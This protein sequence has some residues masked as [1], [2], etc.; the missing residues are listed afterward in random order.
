VAALHNGSI[1]SKGGKFLLEIIQGA[2]RY[3]SV[4]QNG[5]RSKETP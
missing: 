5:V 3:D 1:N 2:E 4:E